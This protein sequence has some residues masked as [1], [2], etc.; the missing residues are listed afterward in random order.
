LNVGITLS[1]PSPIGCFFLDTCVIL[2][3]ILKENTPRIEKLKKDVNLHNIPCY[4]SDSVKQEIYEKIKQT[5]DFLGKVIRETIKFHLEDFRKRNKIPLTDPMTSN[6]IKA[7]E[8]LFSYYYNA[9]KI[10]KVGLQNPISLIEEWTISFL[11]EQLDKGVKI[12]IKQFLRELIKKLLELT[13]YIEDLYDELITFQRKFVKVKN[14]T[15]DSRIVLV[16]KSIGI[17]KK[18]CDHIASA[19]TYQI[20]ERE[21]VV[22]V[23]LDFSSILEKRHLIQ[24]Q[25]DLEC[26][27][28]L[29]ALHHLV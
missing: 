25:L 1:N 13:S 21:K 28:P 16:V 4:I 19:V 20:R 24:K 9:L 5:S 27:D 12:N 11:G 6:D 23:T 7:L 2:S 18:D 26:C 10:T 3:D 29:Y 14:I 17:H 8:D 22:F 15:L